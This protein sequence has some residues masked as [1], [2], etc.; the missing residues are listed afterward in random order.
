MSDI[1]VGIINS[2]VIQK[3]HFRAGQMCRWIETAVNRVVGGTEIVELKL[4][5]TFP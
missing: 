1:S 4:R 3:S 5:S 2:W